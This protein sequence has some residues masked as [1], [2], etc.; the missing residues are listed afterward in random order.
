MNL[1]TAMTNA[2]IQFPNNATSWCKLSSGSDRNEI[3][4]YIV[5][6]Y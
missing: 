6:G 3:M 2:S 4:H 5:L 1:Q